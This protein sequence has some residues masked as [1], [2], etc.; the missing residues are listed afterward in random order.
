LRS[1]TPEVSSVRLRS[2]AFLPTFYKKSRKKNIG[3]RNS[4]L[5]QLKKVYRIILKKRSTFEE[6]KYFRAEARKEKLA[7]VS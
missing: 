2:D 5:I 1:N 6:K 3:F 7:R 4:Y